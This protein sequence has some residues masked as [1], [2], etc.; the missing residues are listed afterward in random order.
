MALPTRPSAG[1]PIAT[2]WG[3]EI[4]DRVLAASGG[5]F[6]GGTRTVAGTPLKVD[7]SVPDADPGGFLDAGNDRVE[8]PTDRQGLYLV[9][10]I[11][12]SVNGD[13]GDS[14]RAYLYLNGASI[15]TGLE[16]NNGG[17]HIAVAVTV[18]QAL[19][20]TDLLEVYAQRKGSGTAPTVKVNSLQLLRLTDDYGA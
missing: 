10:L 1:A 16:D 12:D 4:N 9:N 18:L 19:T 7:L 3:D 13:V 20:A 8:I 2:D 14:T 6:H 11:L 17:T 5:R 15:A